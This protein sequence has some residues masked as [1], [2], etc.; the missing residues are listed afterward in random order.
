MI[1]GRESGFPFTIG[2]QIFTTMSCDS[3]SDSER[4]DT[5][6]K[7]SKDWCGLEIFC[8]INL[9]H[10]PKVHTLKLATWS[11]IGVWPSWTDATL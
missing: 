1:P 6:T 10:T 5:K 7:K 11:G 4:T 2:T 8:E 3:L 9:V